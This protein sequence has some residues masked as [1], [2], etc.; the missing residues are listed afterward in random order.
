MYYIFK[1]LF[2]GKRVNQLFVNIL[3]TIA[4]ELICSSV[5]TVFSLDGSDKNA[6]KMLDHYTMLDYYATIQISKL[7][8]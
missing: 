5:L 2:F 7:Q 3:D 6:E 4:L 1:A 8:A